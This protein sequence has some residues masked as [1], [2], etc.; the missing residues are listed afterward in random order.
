MEALANGRPL[1]EGRR[2][3]NK[4]EATMRRLLREGHSAL[5]LRIAWSVLWERSKIDCVGRQ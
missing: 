3:S 5:K 1:R 2:W 4:E